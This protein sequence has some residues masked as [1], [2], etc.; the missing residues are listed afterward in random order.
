VGD[1]AGLSVGQDRG[2][3]LAHHGTVTDAAVSDTTAD[4]A[5]R[6]TATDQALPPPGPLPGRLPPAEMF[7]A[8]DP[9]FTTRFVTLETGVRVR[10]I[11][12][13]SAPP[14]A[15]VVLCVHGWACSAYSFDTFLP[16]AAR[17]GARALAIDLPGHGLSD[18]P[19]DPDQYTIDALVRA[20]VEVMDRLDVARAIL[21]AHSMGGPIIAQLAVEHPERVRALALIAPAGFGGELS[22]R[23]GRWLTPRI[24]APILPYL[25]P[26]WSISLVFAFTFG[27]LYHPTAR[28]IDEYWA[29]TQFPGFVHAQWDL[30]HRFEWRAG[31]DGSFAAITAPA[32]IIDGS[33][34]HFVVRRWVRRYA[35]TLRHARYVLVDGA[36]H[37]VMQEAPEQV[38]DAI[39]PLLSAP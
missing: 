22:V 32:V 37:V 24:V 20:V 1:Q 25:V 7:P 38:M 30:L 26:R 23:I 8:G 4:D 15:P 6:D 21:V 19:T 39:R 5:S 10:V 34:D 12:C 27:R 35:E 17:D 33:E 31:A 29:P 3:S 14:D 11:E 28:D 18:L 9:R 13:G 2:T 36:G 16:V